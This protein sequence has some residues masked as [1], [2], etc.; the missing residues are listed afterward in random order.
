MVV[1]ATGTLGH[2]LCIEWADRFECWGTVR[3]PVEKPVEE[4]LAPTR[5]IAGISAEE[6]GTVRSALKQ[7]RPDVVVNCVGA[8]KQAES[9]QRPIPAIRINSLFPHELAAACRESSVRMVHIST[10]CVFSG[11]RG[12][13][14][15]DDVPDATDIYGRSKLLGEVSGEGLLTLRTSL[16]GRELQSSLGLLEWLISNRGGSVKGFSRAVFSGL[17]TI[18]L[19]EEIGALLED[20]PEL[21]GLWHLASE[22]IDK[23]EL[24]SM[25]DRK[26]ELGIEIVPDRSVIVDRSLDSSRLC[27]ATERRPRRWEEMVEVLAAD[28]TPYDEIRRELAQ[29]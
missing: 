24:L 25:L 13:Y 10:D 12:R 11:E 17:T 3:R 8:V 1:G 21:E 28:T 23:L 26:L 29:R 9:G 7:A 2:R 19:A 27:R 5:L 14:S 20:Q 22:P 4:L 16:I 15:E 6:P 18:G